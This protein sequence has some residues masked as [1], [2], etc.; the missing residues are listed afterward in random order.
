MTYNGVRYPDFVSATHYGSGDGLCGWNCRHDCWPYWPGL[1]TPNHTDAELEA[2]NAKTIEYNGQM[3]SEYE[4]SQMQRAAERKVRAAKRTYLA[5]DAAGMD[6]TRAAVK[7][8]QARQQLAQFIKDT[9]AYPFDSSARTSVAGFGRSEASKA[10]WAAKTVAGQT[11]SGKSATPFRM[12]RASHSSDQDLGN[13]NPGYYTGNPAYRQNCQRCVVA[14]EMRRRGFDVIAKPAIVDATGKLS[15][16]DTVAGNYQNLFDGLQARW[17]RCKTAADAISIM[18]SYG[19]NA[20]AEVYVWWAPDHTTG[21]ERGAHV[22]V[23]ERI[24]GKTRFIDPQNGVKDCSN[25][26]TMA[27]SSST[28]IARID[29]LAPSKMLNDCIQNRGGKTWSVKKKH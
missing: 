9:G 24:G 25:Y 21:A 18:D 12:L 22:F 29:D 15:A 5:E 14:Y 3:Y 11:A 8:K 2:L 7:L 26:F 10:A 4:I 27:R 16:S 1:S 28:M 20:R 6:T 17:K 13:T 23:A 19:D